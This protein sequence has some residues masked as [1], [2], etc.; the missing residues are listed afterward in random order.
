MANRLW[1]NTFRQAAASIHAVSTLRMTVKCNSLLCAQRQR[2]RHTVLLATIHSP[3]C[4]LWRQ[5][6]ERRLALVGSRCA[7]R[8]VPGHRNTVRG[9]TLVTCAER[10]ASA[11]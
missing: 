9:K 4:K 7:V 10:R 8:E 2:K 11:A 1:Q 6:A 5:H 3:I